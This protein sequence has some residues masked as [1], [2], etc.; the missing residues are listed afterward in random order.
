MKNDHELE[1]PENLDYI[2]KLIDNG[3]FNNKVL[4]SILKNNPELSN[5]IGV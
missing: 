3:K 1:F 2:F 5:N 4:K